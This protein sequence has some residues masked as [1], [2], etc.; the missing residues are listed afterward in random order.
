MFQSFQLAQGP[1]TAEQQTALEAFHTILDKNVH[2]RRMEVW[3]M[4]HASLYPEK[5]SSRLQGGFIPLGR[6]EHDYARMPS[7]AR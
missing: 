7:F 4:Y 1:F 3:L 5:N 2:G 6:K